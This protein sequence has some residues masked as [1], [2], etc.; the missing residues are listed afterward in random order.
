MLLPSLK[1]IKLEQLRRSRL[2]LGERNG[3]LYLVDLLQALCAPTGRGTIRA[4]R[5]H[6]LL[7]LLCRLISLHRRLRHCR[8]QNVLRHVCRLFSVRDLVVP[9]RPRRPCHVFPEGRWRV[10][11]RRG[12]CTT[13][14]R[15]IL[16]AEG[17]RNLCK[18]QILVVFAKP[19]LQ[20]IRRGTG[21]SGPYCWWSFA[22]G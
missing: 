20:R 1:L 17:Q 15:I 8:A 13:A 10:G 14:G 16:W 6:M 4:R 19:Q 21:R 18:I 7:R 9:F 5:G 11:I 12:P 22:H 3:S 2:A